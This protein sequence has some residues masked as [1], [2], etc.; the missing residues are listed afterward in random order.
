M[1]SELN[2]LYKILSKEII[3]KNGWFLH[4]PGYITSVKEIMDKCL[5]NEENFTKYKDLQNIILGPENF[6]K[7][8]QSFY[9]VK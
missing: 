7:K 6:V 2:N 3:I 8:Y 4:A 9:K 1:T 5:N